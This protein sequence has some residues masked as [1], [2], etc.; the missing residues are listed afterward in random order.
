V[1]LYLSK[2]SNCDNL[3]YLAY[4]FSKCPHNIFKKK[5]NPK[6]KKKKSKKYVGV[7]EPPHRW[8]LATLFGLGWFGHTQAGA[9]PSGPRG[10]SAAPWVKR[11]F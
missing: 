2:L 8:W 7:A 4:L 10:G 9:P 11:K 3:T 1:T 6:T 5:K